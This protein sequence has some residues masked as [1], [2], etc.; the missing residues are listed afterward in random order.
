MHERPATTLRELHAALTEHLAGYGDELG[1]LP[2]EIT[3]ED[4]TWASIVVTADLCGGP[5]LTVE[6]DP[7][8][9]EL[10]CGG[11]RCRLPHKRPR[12][13]H[14][15]IARLFAER[16]RPAIEE[17]PVPRLAVA[18]PHPAPRLPGAF[19]GDVA[20]IRHRCRQA[21]PGWHHGCAYG[22][23]A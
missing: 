18:S 23:R 2:V 15:L 21:S 16:D 19:S 5:V 10:E 22:D 17:R 9:D 13:W 12:W 8:W 7:F 3:T 1:D 11:S 4:G 14:R 20:R 6:S